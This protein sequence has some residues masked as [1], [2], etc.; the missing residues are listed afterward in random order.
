MLTMRSVRVLAVVVVE[1]LHHDG[2]HAAQVERPQPQDL[3]RRAVGGHAGV[4]HLES[5]QGL[6][7]LRDGLVVPDA[8]ALGERVAVHDQ[9]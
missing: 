4:Q 5:G 6:V 3:A 7:P 9:L 1:V 8:P 2:A